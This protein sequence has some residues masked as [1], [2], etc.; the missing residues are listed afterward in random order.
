MLLR[1]D[2]LASLQRTGLVFQHFENEKG[3]DLHLA[4]ENN[5]AEV[6][7]VLAAYIR[8]TGLRCVPRKSG[9]ISVLCRS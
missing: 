5:T 1:E 9:V 8:A 2:L 7:E 4:P 3:L 6:R